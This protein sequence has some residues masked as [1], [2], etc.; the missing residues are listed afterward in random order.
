MI[1]RIL[2]PKDVRPVSADDLKRPALRVTTYMD[3]RTVVPPELSDAPPLDGKS[4]IPQHLPLGVLV[5]RTLVP[6]GMAVKRFEIPEGQPEYHT[7]QILD[8]RI[9]VPARIE[10]L[11]REEAEKELGPPPEMTAELREVIEPDIF[12]TGD[13]NLL[14]E[15]EEKRDTKYDLVTRV[16]SVIAHICLIIFLILSPKIFP[17]QVPT[18]EEVNLGQKLIDIYMPPESAIPRPPAP[19]V[20]ISP[21]ELNRVAPPRV[22]AQPTPLPPAPTPAPNPERAPNDLP[23][24][25]TPHVPVNPEAVPTPTQPTQP[26]P[27]RL[28]PMLPTTPTPNHLNL[29]LPQSSPGKAI[30]DQLSDAIHHAGGQGGI[31]PVGPM[32]PGRGPGMGQGYQILSDTQGVDFSSYIQRLLATLRRNWEVVMP[33]S[34]RMGDNGVVYTTFTIYPNGSVQAPDPNLERTSGKE[35]LDNAAMSAIHA[36]N[37]F[38]PLP[39]QFHGPYLKLRIIFLYN[40]TPEQ[41]NHP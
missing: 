4:S 35:P 10:P 30:Q 37:P 21:K 24:A 38:E 40:P 27:S 32:G 23:A 12:I 18:Q 39:S 2:V 7:E 17:V 33:E 25:P 26:T 9:V 5:E 41:M 15:P 1:Q 20:H 31:Q 3:E 13:A 34:A 11:T 22:E 16:A 28:E 6:R 8:S 29:S 14:M 19:K 36:S